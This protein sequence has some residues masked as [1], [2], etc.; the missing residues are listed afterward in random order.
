M[1]NSSTIVD[2]I[3]SKLNFL[4]N[5][6][7]IHL[8]RK[9]LPSGKPV[10]FGLKTKEDETLNQNLLNS[11]MY[12]SILDGVPEKE[13]SS[14]NLNNIFTTA[15]G[16]YNTAKNPI[17]NSNQVSFISN[18]HLPNTNLFRSVQ[19][20]QT[21]QNKSITQNLNFYNQ[22][23]ENGYEPNNQE[24]VSSNNLIGVLSTQNTN[25]NINSDKKCFFM[26]KK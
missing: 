14:S 17:F 20:P 26:V 9:I 2:I 4:L 8:K 23:F 19:V 13:N 18:T 1:D 15:S 10:I 6:S 7:N 24:K 5:Q 12:N 22:S 25:A 21:E 16:N 11:N 3:P